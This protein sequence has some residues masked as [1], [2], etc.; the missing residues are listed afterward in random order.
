MEEPRDYQSVK[1]IL[2]SMVGKYTEDVPLMLH[3]FFDRYASEI[4]AGAKTHAD[5]RNEEVNKDDVLLSIQAREQFSFNSG[6]S[7][8]ELKMQA[9]VFNK[10]KKLPNVSDKNA[11]LL[12][13]EEF[14]LLAPNKQIKKKTNAMDIDKFY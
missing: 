14:C 6:Q 1:R 5:R 3:E 13:N 10:E 12:P 4:L 9:S 11:L 8:E 2:N 7:I